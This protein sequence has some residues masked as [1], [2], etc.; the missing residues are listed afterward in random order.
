M[1]ARDTQPIAT[2]DRHRNNN[3]ATAVSE[4][5]LLAARINLTRKKWKQPMKWQTYY[6]QTDIWKNAIM[7]NK[8]KV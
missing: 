3:M 6:V 1:P 7:T 8:Q 4:M 5:S 2:D